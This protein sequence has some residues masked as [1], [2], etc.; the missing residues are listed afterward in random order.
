M[1]FEV[2]QRAAG[3]QPFAPDAFAAQ[4]G[5]ELP[6]VVNGYL[7]GTGQLVAAEISDDAFAVR[8]TFDL[9]PAVHGWTLAGRGRYTVGS[10]V[11]A[12][13]EPR[14]RIRSGPHLDLT[15]PDDKPQ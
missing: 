2:A 8:L 14:T 13:H 4:I 3:D 12:P 9:P 1:L 11:D 5:Q 6:V 10:Y 15:R 7:L